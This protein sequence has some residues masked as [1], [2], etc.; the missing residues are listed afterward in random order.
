[1]STLTLHDEDTAFRMHSVNNSLPTGLLLVGEYSWNARHPR[2]LKADGS[3]KDLCLSVQLE[4]RVADTNVAS[5][6]SKPPLV[7][8]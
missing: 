1:M 8:R 6:I 7:A 3:M 2:S 4:L 5:D